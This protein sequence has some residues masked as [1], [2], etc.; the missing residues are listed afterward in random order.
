MNVQS[1]PYRVA[2]QSLVKLLT[3]STTVPR[4]WLDLPTETQKQVAQKLA[5][6]LM[7]MRSIRTPTKVDQHAESDE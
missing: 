5:P 3:P 6:L 7:R 1:K 4:P 2:S